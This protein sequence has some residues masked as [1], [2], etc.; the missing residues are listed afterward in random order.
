MRNLNF[1]NLASNFGMMG[2]AK[3]AVVKETVIDV[4]NGRDQ[5]QLCYPV[6]VLL[7]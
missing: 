4:E 6:G 7:D 5:F 1:Q 2:T 3:P